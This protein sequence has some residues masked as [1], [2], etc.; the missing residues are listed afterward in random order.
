MQQG[1]LNPALLAAGAPV[2]RGQFLGLA[3]N[4]GNSTG[5]HLHVHTIKGTAPESGPLRPF[6]YRDMWVMDQSDLKPPDPSGPWV[7]ATD[8]GLPGVNALIWPTAT[9]PSWSPGSSSCTRW[10]ATSRGGTKVTSMR[11][12]ISLSIGSRVTT[13][14]CRTRADTLP[15]TRSPWRP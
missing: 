2:K 4:A 13:Q 11:S 3:G 5:P 6:P 15:A 10:S 14:V 8:Q 9:K 7:K 1:S 12:A